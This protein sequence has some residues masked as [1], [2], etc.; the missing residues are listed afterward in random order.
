MASKDE[1]F[2]A[3]M[4]AFLRHEKQNPNVSTDPNTF[5]DADGGTEAHVDPDTGDFDFSD[6]DE[7]EDEITKGTTEGMK[8]DSEDKGGYGAETEFSEEDKKP[9]QNDYGADY[10]HKFAMANKAF[11]YVFVVPFLNWVEFSREDV[12]EQVAEIDKQIEKGYFPQ[13]ER[14]CQFLMDAHQ[15]LEAQLKP[16]IDYCHQQINNSAE[17]SEECNKLFSDWGNALNFN[18]DK[19]TYDVYEMYIQRFDEIKKQGVTDSDMNKYNNYCNMSKQLLEENKQDASNSGSGFDDGTSDFEAKGITVVELYEGENDEE[20]SRTFT[21]EEWRSYLASLERVK[22]SNG[23][24]GYRGTTPITIDMGNGEH[25]NTFDFSLE[26]VHSH[27]PNAKGYKKVSD[28]M[29][30]TSSDESTVYNKPNEKPETKYCMW[31]IRNQKQYVWHICH[32]LEEYN[33]YKAGLQKVADADGNVEYYISNGLYMLIDNV[34]P[35]CKM[36]RVKPDVDYHFIF[37]KEIELNTNNSVAEWIVKDSTFEDMVYLRFRGKSAFDS[38]LSS[39]LSTA[40]TENGVTYYYDSTVG[41]NKRFTLNLNSIYKDDNNWVL[42]IETSITT[43]Y[44]ENHDPFENTDNGSHGNYKNFYEADNENGYEGRQDAYNDYSDTEPLYK[45]V[46]ING[47]PVSYALLRAPWTNE[48]YNHKG[49]D[50]VNFFTK[51]FNADL[52][53]NVN[54]DNITSIG[55]V[56]G[57]P[58]LNGVLL[59]IADIKP[60][61]FNNMPAEYRTKLA[62]NDLYYLVGW[63]EWVLK[64]NK[65]NITSM[66]FS[67]EEEYAYVI[68]R[69]DYQR[70]FDRYY[71]LETLT[72]GETTLTRE[73]VLKQTPKFTRAQSNS[74]FRSRWDRATD[75]YHLN[76][77][78]G[79]RS[80][81]EYA[82]KMVTDYRERSDVHGIRK[83]FG[84]VNRHLWHAITWVTDFGVTAVGGA[85]NIITGK[86]AVTQND[87]RSSP[88]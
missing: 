42:P 1:A 40:Q 51:Q 26:G 88:V 6:E 27:T 79:T 70:V 38:W 49:W 80:A 41:L 81:K 50:K 54:Y 3:Y 7:F 65:K 47:K 10:K 83:L 69:L 57:V 18:T 76:I 28:L 72:V 15:E 73:D 56:Q 64:Y 16:K 29:I 36:E 85:K 67:R 53:A 9:I 58:Y 21:V 87:F 13:A 82:W 44:K 75:G 32:N 12:N 17:T 62:H 37:M 24:E 34:V 20:P 46:N 52:T 39:V 35:T 2:R 31:Y 77:M 55:V 61:M 25:G 8:P 78:N 14:C 86:D 48:L 30:V 63:K 74:S 33:E 60:D 22:L 5:K 19:F 68:G 59:S 23:K 45:S 4:N 66:Y 11:A 84:L 71:N 43:G